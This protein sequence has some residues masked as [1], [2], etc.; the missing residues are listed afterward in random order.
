MYCAYFVVQLQTFEI[1]N[2]DETVITNRLPQMCGHIGEDI[3]NGVLPMSPCRNKCANST[4]GASIYMCFQL[5]TVTQ[6]IQGRSTFQVVGIIYSLW[7]VCLV[8]MD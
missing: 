6:C 7:L 4:E 8:T 5:Y 2:P 3:A 1:W